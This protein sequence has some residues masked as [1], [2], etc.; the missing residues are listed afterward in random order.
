M[1]KLLKH[2]SI[3]CFLICTQVGFSQTAISFSESGLKQA[4]NRAKTENKPVLLW[5]YA[6]WCPHC[7]TMK[8]GVFTNK[9]VAE[10]FNKTFICV[11]QD[12][13]KGEGVDLNKEL[14]IASFPTFIFYNPDGTILYRVEGEFKSEAF[15]Q[16]GKNAL[17]PKRQL[18]YLKLQF[19]KDVSNSTNCYEYLRALKKG[20]M[21]HSTVVK[22]YFATQSDRQ[23][24]SEINW[25]IIS[26]GISDIN[27]REMQFVISHQHEFS[28]IVSPERV[29]R[30]LDYLI[31]EL[32]YPLVE[33]T[34]TVNYL[35]NRKLAVQIHSYSTDSLIFYYDLRIWALTKNWNVYRE[36]A[37]QSTKIFAWNNHAQL[38]E[39]AGNL[40]NNISDTKALSL[41]V[42]WAQRSLA[43]DE[44]YDTYLL[45]ARLHLKLNNMKEAIV[46]AQKAKT[47]SAKYEWEGVEAEKLLKELNNQN[48]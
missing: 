32:L 36:T 1:S 19:E 26:N 9:A 18:P 33:S 35:A 29:K 40:L 39:I 22:R 28:T 17:T 6:T 42:L 14:K 30:K 4:L 44:E 7:K 16:E 15:M 11:S 45:C 37:L 20:G 47:L 24:L 46:M 27:S 5:C 10:Y 38:T 48:K 41:A 12:M 8:E 13:E 25:R 3:F 31:K 21:N 23:L 43:L 34:D 2:I